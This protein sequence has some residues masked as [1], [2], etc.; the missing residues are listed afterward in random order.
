MSAIV[1]IVGR[2]N[3]G[4]STFF[5]RLIKRREAIVDAVSGVTRDRHYGK[6][7][8]NGVEFSVIDTGGYVVGSDDSF[9]KEI[10]KQVSL[11][12]DEADA[13]VFMVDVEDGIT[14]M[15][16][17]VADLLRKSK[18]PVFVA[19]NKVDSNNRVANSHEFYAFGFENVYTLSS[20]NGSGTG[21]LLDDLVKILPERESKN[22]EDLPRFAVVGRPNAGKS[23][24]I[25]ALIGEDRYIVT[26]IAGTTRDAIDTK[27][28]RFGFEFNL[29]DTAG[30]RRKSKVK[31]DLEFY[32]VMRSI[33]AIEHADVCILMIDATRGFEGQDSNIF[34]LAQRNRKGIVILVNKWDLVEKQTNTA[35]NFEAIIRKE[36]EP[37]TDVP[38]IFI[39]ALNKQRIYKAIEQA[40]EVYQNRSKRI[41][42][43]KLNE[44]MLP[45]IENR[46]PPA[47][48]GKYI[49]IKFCTQLPTPMPQFVF[50][51][52]LPQYV[53]EPYRRFIEN[54]LR[55][56]FDFKGV[57]IDVYFRKK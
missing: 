46:P 37:F 38:I 42:T 50:F 30:I 4:K 5:N 40:V 19:V 26:D 20:I 53:K 56:H 12:I 54:Q 44:V 25:N 6:T 28:N 48:K 57:P 7:D 43:S 23:S 17:T 15:D 31:E 33:R 3:V 32:S 11:A 49:K 24:F 1:A 29:V 27:Y 35:K 36:I 51:A 14:G 52:N 22:D 47:I 13:I 10:D 45:I 21:E 16:E 55:E 2:P 18:K 39:S 34:W 8:W 9:E 41:P